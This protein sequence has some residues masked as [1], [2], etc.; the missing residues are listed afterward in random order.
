[1]RSFLCRY[2]TWI[3]WRVLQGFFMVGRR[4]SL[5]VSSA[6]PRQRGAGTIGR[7]SLRPPRPSFNRTFTATLLPRGDGR[8]PPVSPSD[9]KIVLKS[10][11]RSVPRRW[12]GTTCRYRNC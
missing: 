8:F 7:F 1:M 3:A 10:P 5:D 9:S 4:E 2:R 11:G 6:G 12:A